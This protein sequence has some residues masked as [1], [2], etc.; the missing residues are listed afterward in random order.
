MSK[1]N[2]SHA[3]TFW[4][5]R[6]LDWENS[7]YGE[8]A[9]SMVERVAGRTSSSV[10][11]RRSTAISLLAPHLAGRHVVELGCASGLLAGTILAM[12][13]ASYSG[14]DISGVAIKHA[15]ALHQ[16]SPYADRISFSA[17]EVMDLS[18]FGDQVVFSLGLLDWLDD[19]GMDRVFACCRSAVYLH[20]FSE[21]RWSLTQLVH[22]IYAAIAYGHQAPGYVPRYYSEAELSAVIARHRPD[23]PSV[24]RNKCL[25]F[26]AFATNLPMEGA[27]IT[28]P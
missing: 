21:K 19:S 13:A 5:S 22:R 14:H 25:R 2:T 17:I 1:M 9:G 24:L 6:I 4:N 8:E 10:R 23:R 18:D 11:F 15:I 26:G 12:G 3:K 16:D 7:R 28:P 27:E 20:S